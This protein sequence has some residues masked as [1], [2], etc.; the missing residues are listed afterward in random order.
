MTTVYRDSTGAAIVRRALIGRRVRHFV[1]TGCE[2]G[3]DWEGHVLGFVGDRVSVG[4][5]D[6]GGP[7][8][9]SPD[10]IVVPAVTDEMVER[11]VRVYKEKKHPAFTYDSMRSERQKAL[12]R[13]EVRAILEAAI[14]R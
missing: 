9:C 3:F 2:P 6:G 10:E 13:E 14:E 7:I 11:C 4:R 1:D 12:C 8:L 5:D